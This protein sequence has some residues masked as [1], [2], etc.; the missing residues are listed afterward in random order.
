VS[1]PIAAVWI[2]ERIGEHLVANPNF[3]RRDRMI[4]N[5]RSRTQII[6]DRITT[7]AKVI[8][9]AASLITGGAI[10]SFLDR[11]APA[12]GLGL[13]HGRL[14]ATRD[15]TP[16]TS[17]GLSRSACARLDRVGRP[18]NP[19]NGGVHTAG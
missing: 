8:G 7:R 13:P 17:S 9:S 15:S 12:E 6:E 5:V 2:T 10:D 4:T 1:T 11:P 14:T 3:M 18:L 19:E 16:R